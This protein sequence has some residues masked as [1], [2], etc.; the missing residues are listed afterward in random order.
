VGGIAGYL[1]AGSNYSVTLYGT[2]LTNTGAIKGKLYVG[3]L[4]GYVKTDSTNSSVVEVVATG[5]VTATNNYGKRYGFAEN[6]KF[7]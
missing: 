3:G 6:V 4:F 7:E 5:T 2:N 1:A